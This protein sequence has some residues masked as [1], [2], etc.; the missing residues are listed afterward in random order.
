MDDKLPPPDS[1]LSPPA[2]S[3]PDDLDVS[4]CI[5][6][7]SWIDET[8]W[9]Q[10]FGGLYE[11]REPEDPVTAFYDDPDVGPPPDSEQESW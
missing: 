5:G 7:P 3:G 6:L 4:A 1:P 2:G 9:A 11:E 10:R 8:G